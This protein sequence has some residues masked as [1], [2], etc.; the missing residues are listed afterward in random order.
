MVGGKNGLEQKTKINN[1]QRAVAKKRL[2]VVQCG[3]TQGQEIRKCIP[4]HG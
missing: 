4:F 3:L 1:D 2:I